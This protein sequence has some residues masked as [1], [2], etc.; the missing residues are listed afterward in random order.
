[1]TEITQKLLT[2]EMIPIAPMNGGDFE[3]LV[4]AIDGYNAECF[5]AQRIGSDKISILFEKEH[6]RYG[7]EIITKYFQ[8]EKPGV[9]S[10]GHKKEEIYIEIIKS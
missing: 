7:K 10:W 3:K 2:E 8:F 5:I 4:I 1:M 6:P 9:I